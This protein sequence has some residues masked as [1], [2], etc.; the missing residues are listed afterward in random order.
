MAITT[1]DYLL[2]LSM[3]LAAYISANRRKIIK[4]LIPAKKGMDNYSLRSTTELNN[5]PASCGE[6]KPKRLN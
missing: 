6:F 1:L 2:V 4:R 5:P 3:T